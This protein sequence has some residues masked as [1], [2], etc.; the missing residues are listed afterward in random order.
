[1]R[2]IRLASARR[3]FH[4]ERKLIRQ[5]HFLIIEEIGVLFFG[6]FNP[7]TANL[8]KHN[9]LDTSFCLIRCSNDRCFA[10]TNNDEFAAAQCFQNCLFLIDFPLNIA[11]TRVSCSRQSQRFIQSCC[12]RLDFAAGLTNNFFAFFDRDNGAIIDN[13][14]HAACV[15]V[16]RTFII[17]KVKETIVVCR[18][19]FSRYGNRLIVCIN[20]HAKFAV[21]CVVIDRNS[22][23]ICRCC[24]GK[25]RGP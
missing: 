12:N 5:A 24:L 10:G 1:M 3:N 19:R 16:A 25:G 21:H 23:L 22:V 6:A 9:Y 18:P 2:C 20:Y 14:F 11:G 13:N 4:M 17:Y 7:N 8:I 15:L